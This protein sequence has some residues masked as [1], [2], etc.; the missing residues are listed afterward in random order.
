[1]KSF[2]KLSSHQLAWIY[3]ITLVVF[4][5]VPYFLYLRSIWHIVIFSLAAIILFVCLKL[6]VLKPPHIKQIFQEYL[7]FIIGVYFAIII[8]LIKDQTVVSVHPMMDVQFE[9]IKNDNP[10][11]EG[12]IYSQYLYVTAKETAPE[13]LTLPI[14]VNN[15]GN[16]TAKNAIVNL[17]ISLTNFEFIKC[18]H[19]EVIDTV[20]RD[21]VG[22]DASIVCKGVE[23]TL[24]LSY[25][26]IDP[27]M[28]HTSVFIDSIVLVTKR[29]FL[30]KSMFKKEG[31]WDYAIIR[32]ETSYDKTLNTNI[33]YGLLWIVSTTATIDQKDFI[34]EKLLT[35][36]HSIAK[37]INTIYTADDFFR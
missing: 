6:N 13:T 33:Q 4:A 31:N 14:I 25:K 12:L 1:M 27:V 10:L 26:L 29:P 28:V 20:D 22:K 30:Y 23:S 9:W 37:G 3:I 11:N 2:R 17:A 19:M 18:N 21:I 5:I 16:E 15:F 24:V 36:N 35:M 8:P 32:T 34:A 7:F